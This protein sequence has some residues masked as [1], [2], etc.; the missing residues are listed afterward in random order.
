MSN[1]G[2]GASA[3]DDFEDFEEPKP[4]TSVK[5]AIARWDDHKLSYAVRVSRR[6]EWT[7][8]RHPSSACG[9]R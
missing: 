8:A 1:S 9:E 6:A 3:P 7:G 5:E 4:A 2:E